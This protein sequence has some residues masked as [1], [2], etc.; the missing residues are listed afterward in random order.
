[1]SSYKDVAKLDIKVQIESN[2]SLPMYT[3]IQTPNIH[4]MVYAR[5]RSVNELSIRVL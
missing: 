4:I 5:Q 1:M 2:L 3:Q